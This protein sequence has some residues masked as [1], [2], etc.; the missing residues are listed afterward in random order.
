MKSGGLIQCNALAVCDMFK[1]SG[2]MGKHLMKD[3]SENH[4]EATVVPF[5]AMVEYHPISAHDQSGLHQFGEKIPGIL[6]GYAL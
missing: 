4:L 6:L 2:Q 1:T 5:G 3:D